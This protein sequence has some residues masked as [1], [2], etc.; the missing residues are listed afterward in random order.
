M[1]TLICFHEVEDVEHRSAD[2]H[3]VAGMTRS[4]EK[5]DTLARSVPSRSSAMS[6]TRSR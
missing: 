6:S 4:P 3:T 2:G 5:T 1:T